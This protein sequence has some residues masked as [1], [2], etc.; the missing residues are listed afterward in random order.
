M[1][2]NLS[3]FFLLSIAL[4]T[5]VLAGTLDTLN[6]TLGATH[7]SEKCSKKVTV[8]VSG[9]LTKSISIYEK[10]TCRNQDDYMNETDK[11]IAFSYTKWEAEFDD[12]DPTKVAAESGVAML[13]C[14]GSYRCVKSETGFKGQDGKTYVVQIPEHLTDGSGKERL[15]GLVF[16]LQDKTERFKYGRADRAKTLFIDLIKEYQ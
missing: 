9:F 10:T 1:S 16:S 4:P 13:Q 11:A 2:R 6:D 15:P 14:K 5:L 7:Q 12:L 8:N 3:M